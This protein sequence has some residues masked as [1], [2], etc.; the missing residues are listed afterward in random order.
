M[1]P[2]RR[3][4]KKPNRSGGAGRKRGVGKMNTRP[5]LASAAAK[6]RISLCEIRRKR[7]KELPL[8]HPPMRRQH[9]F[10]SLSIS[11]IFWYHNNK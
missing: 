9:N 6:I 10:Y 2:R 11:Q 1:M 8:P 7:I 3:R 4:G 5:A